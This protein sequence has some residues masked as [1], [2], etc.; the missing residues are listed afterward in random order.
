MTLDEMHKTPG[1]YVIQ[2]RSG[3]YLVETD[4]QRRCFH[5]DKDT[6]ARGDCLRRDGWHEPW[7]LAI[8]GPLAR[9][10]SAEATLTDR[11]VHEASREFSERD[12]QMIA[13]RV[14]AKWARE[15]LLRR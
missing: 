2:G 10:P 1:V 9:I 7:T 5:L 3:C 6:L 12:E 8:L 13:F 11:A 14:G 4:Q 15:K